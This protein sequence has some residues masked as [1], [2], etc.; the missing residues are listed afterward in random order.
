MRCDA[1]QSNLYFGVK[2]PSKLAKRKYTGK[3]P[4]FS[5]TSQEMRNRKQIGQRKME[6]AERN[7][8]S[9]QFEGWDSDERFYDLIHYGR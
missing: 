5:K 4:D 3:N 6:K 1:I 8:K 7:A 2:S 9:R